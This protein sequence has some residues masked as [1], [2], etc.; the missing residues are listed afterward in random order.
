MN[1]SLQ[2][3]VSLVKLIGTRLVRG[4]VPISVAAVI[5]SDGLIELE[6]V[7]DVPSAVPG[8]PEAS[9]PALLRAED[10]SEPAYARVTSWPVDPDMLSWRFNDEFC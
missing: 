4:R 10:P 8:E 6:A 2:E 7:F 9:L 5:E 1:P 3:I